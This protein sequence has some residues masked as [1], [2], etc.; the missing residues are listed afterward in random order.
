MTQVQTVSAL[1]IIAHQD[2]LYCL[3]QAKHADTV[4][5]KVVI[6]SKCFN[7]VDFIQTKI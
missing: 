4:Q 2:V 7:F 3:S 1:L 5:L 6:M